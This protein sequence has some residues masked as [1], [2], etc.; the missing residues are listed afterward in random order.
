MKLLIWIIIG[1]VG[2]Y[3]AALLFVC[4]T[5]R[6]FMYFPPSASASSDVFMAR[7]EQVIAIEVDGIGPINAIYAPPPKDG[8][9]VILF[10]H[11]NGSA[12]HEYAQHFDAFKSWGAGFL[13]VEY[14]GYAANIGAPSEQAI[15]K[16]AQAHYD[17]L[18]SN[19]ITPSQIIIFGHSLGAAVAVDLAKNNASAGLVIGSPFLSMQAMGRKQMPWFPSSLLMKDK[20]RSDL[21]ILGV[22]E[23]L[24]VL[25]GDQDELIPHA[26][27]KALYELHGGTKEFVSIKGGR[28]QLWGAEMSK[29]IQI[30]V[31]AHSSSQ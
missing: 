7:G 20:Y 3:L 13:A 30:F 16:S 12:A 9:P 22:E 26:Q 27:G 28:H 21:K 23:D 19:D 18:R 1:A 15:L 11:G 14:P 2:L 25:H 31:R 8:A 24:L 6:N 10:I 29:H 5:Q 4:V 17:Y